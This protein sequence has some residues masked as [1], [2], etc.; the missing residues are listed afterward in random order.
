MLNRHRARY[1]S[2]I[3]SEWQLDIALRGLLKYAPSATS[4][5]LAA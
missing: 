1:R 3:G 5:T 4:Q 2:D